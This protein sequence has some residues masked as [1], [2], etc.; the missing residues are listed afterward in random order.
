MSDDVF[1][2]QII[3]VNSYHNYS[4]K[5]LDRKFEIIG[6]HPDGS[7]EIARFKKRKYFAQCFIQKEKINL[8]KL[9]IN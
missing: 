1:L 7:I 5:N 9:S 6:K 2:N 3:N 4:I 8:K